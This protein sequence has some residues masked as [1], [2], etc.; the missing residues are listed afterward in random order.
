MLNCNRAGFVMRDEMYIILQTIERHL[1]RIALAV[2][3]LAEIE[4]EGEEDDG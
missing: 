4:E 3:K 2:E 1:L